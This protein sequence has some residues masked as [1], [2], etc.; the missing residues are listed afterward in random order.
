MALLHVVRREPQQ[1]GHA[2]S[3]WQLSS[4]LQSSP[5]LH[6]TSLG[7]L[8]KL[9]K[10]LD[11]VYKGG[12]SYLHSPDQHYE[13]KVSYLDRCRQ[14]AQADPQRYVF[15]YIDEV[16]FS[17]QPSLAKAYEQ[18]GHHQPLARR[19][20]RKDTLCR[21]IGALN[22][23]TGQVT[24]RQA[25]R[26]S[27]KVLSGF[28][29]A[30]RADYPQAE[31]IYAAQ[32]NWPVHVHPDVLARLQ[33][34]TFPFWPNTPDNWPNRPHPR[35]VRDQ[36]PI[37]LVFLPTYASWLNP[38]EK[39]WRWLRQ[40]VLHLHRLSDDW[41]TLKQLVLDFMAQFR[42]GSQELLHYVGLLPY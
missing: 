36:L 39:L 19:S 41:L 42:A 27:L 7:G 24:Y 22:A 28:Y 18:V 30:L 3:R 4:I 26:I 31:V 20:Y 38:I 6:L 2:A 32:D 33:P 13:A 29:A 14:R 9:L 17:R 12:R 34:Q 23:L 5:W 40:K 21:A 25:S 10:R 37:Q 16:A 1:F 11:I 35:A 8:S 15:V